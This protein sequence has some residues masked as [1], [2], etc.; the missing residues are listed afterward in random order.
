MSDLTVLIDVTPVILSMSVTI[1][2][3][4]SVLPSSELSKLSL[5]I[6]YALFL[7]ESK[8]RDEFTSLTSCNLVFPAIASVADSPV[9]MAPTS[10]AM[11]TGST[12]IVSVVNIFLSRILLIIA[13]FCAGLR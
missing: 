3:M 10:T 7:I 1:A 5:I 11:Y 8:L 2:V 9:E 6:V 4:S 12:T 13:D